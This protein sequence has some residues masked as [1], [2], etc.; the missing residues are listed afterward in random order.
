ME[1]PALQMTDLIALIEKSAINYRVQVVEGREPGW[2]D[3]LWPSGKALSWTRVTEQ[4]G[5]RT[6]DEWPVAA[7]VRVFLDAGE[8]HFQAKRW[9]DARDAYLRAA[10]HD[11]KCYRALLYAGDA[12]MFAGDAT[13]ALEHHRRAEQINPNDHRV[14][15]FQ[16]AA[17]KCLQ[18]WDEMREALSQVLVLRPQ[19]PSVVEALS[20]S[21]LPAGM[22]ISVEPLRPAIAV[23]DDDGGMLLQVSPDGGGHWTG[24]GMGK[25]L[26]LAERRGQLNQWSPAEERECLHILAEQYQRGLAT[27]KANREP[28]LDRLSQAIA[29]ELL[30]AFVTYEIHSRMDPHIVL[31]LPP[32]ERGDVGTYVRRYVIWPG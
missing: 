25:A 17:L 7:D 27:G 8:E 28:A 23:H 19:F 21:E 9:L 6:V 16:A 30:N 10:E 22:R 5:Q 18:R 29:A 12:A 1:S 11:P 31:R 2:A 32:S 3:D 20:N 4:D 14:C 15:L 24:Y 26:W 13:A